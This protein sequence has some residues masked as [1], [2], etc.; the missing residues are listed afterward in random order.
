MT[1]YHHSSYSSQCLCCVYQSQLNLPQ[2]CLI[3][4]VDTLWNSTFYMLHRFLEQHIAVS[5]TKAEVNA[6][7]DLAPTQW[8]LAQK[9]CSVLA[10]INTITY[11]LSRASASE[12][13]IIPMVAS[14]KASICSTL[15][16]HGGSKL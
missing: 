4:K 1:H 12:A 5:A 3:Q 11:E 8:Q 6:N 2:H 13:L 14:F 15:S 7:H 16:D 10:P 9:V